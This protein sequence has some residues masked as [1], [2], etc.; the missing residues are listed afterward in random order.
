MEWPQA[1]G[2]EGAWQGFGLGPTG[3][4]PT[5]GCH[6]AHTPASGTLP[7]R[8]V[9]DGDALCPLLASRHAMCES[10]LQRLST[11]LWCTP[12][13]PLRQLCACPRWRCCRQGG[14]TRA[15]QI[16]VHTR[17]GEAHAGA[18]SGEGVDAHGLKACTLTAKCQ[19]SAP[20]GPL[21]KPTGTPL[22]RAACT[23]VACPSWPHVA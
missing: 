13:P 7:C 9:D 21:Y 19:P 15:P 14:I 3:P 23:A 11:P 5:A 4:A 12:L 8:L 18:R 17:C 1:R 2:S 10:P 22:L 6:S 16:A 20:P